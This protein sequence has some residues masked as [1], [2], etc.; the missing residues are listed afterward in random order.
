MTRFTSLALSAVTALGLAVTPVVG[1]V[2][3][4]WM[5]IV[6][7]AQAKGFDISR[8]ERLEGV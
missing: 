5:A 2:P 1:G 4:V 8:R 3:G 7:A 6:E